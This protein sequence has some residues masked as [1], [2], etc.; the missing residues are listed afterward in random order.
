MPDIIP[1]NK[2]HNSWLFVMV[3]LACFVISVGVRYQQ[4]EIW[5]ATPANYFVGER[6]MM[7]TLD[8]PYWLR[9]AREYNE[10]VYGIDILRNY[11]GQVEYY[12]AI[13]TEFADPAFTNSTQV[14]PKLEYEGI[15][16]LSFLIS[17][18]TT[19]FDNNYY[20]TGTLIIPVLAS[21]FILPLGVYFFLIGIPAVGLI[22]GLIGTFA[23]GYYMRS[24]IGRID[25]DMLN[26][27]FPIFASLLILMSSTAKTERAIVFY[28]ASAGLSFY[29]FQWWYGRA[30]FA[31]VYFA[32]LVFCLFTRQVR[33]RIIMFS[34][35]LFI[36]FTY[37]ETFMNGTN[38]VKGFVQT[39]FVIEETATNSVIE[40]GINPAI[41][42]NVMNTI[43]EADHVPIEVVMRR[44]L[45]NSM[46]GWVG[47]IAFFGLAVL[48]W[49]ELLPLLPMLALGMLSFQSSNRFIMYLAPFIGMGLGWLLQ[50]GIETMFL[51]IAKY[52]DHKILKGKEKSIKVKRERQ[53][54]LWVSFKSLVTG[55]DL[56]SNS[57]ETDK[58]AKEES[59]NVK[60]S[61][62]KDLD[63]DWFRWARQGVLYLGIATFFWVISPQ[64]AI[65]FVPGPSIHPRLYA[66]FL[67][68]KKRVPENSAL[69]TWWDYGYAITDA[70]SLATFH[71]GG[72]QNGPKTYF[73][74]R[75][76]TS[77]NPM[78]FYKI[79]QYLSTEGGS[80]INRNNT[81]PDELLRAIRNPSQTPRNPIY[82]F[83]TADMTGK[84]G[85]ISR[86]GSWD[87]VN[88]GSQ[89][90]G[91]RNLTC[92]KVTNVE[93]NCRGAKI[94]LKD[95]KINNQIPLRRLVFIRDG[96]VFREQKFGR[97]EGYTIQL[98]VAGRQ[99][100]EVQLIDEVVFRSNYNQMF[101]LG[102]Y[103]KD[104]FEET[105]NAFPYSRL[106][107]VKF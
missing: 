30:G 48:R 32:V 68:V 42:P 17:C 64:T 41:F 74:A 54:S 107:G 29:L 66:T 27:F 67:E 56:E 4:F 97:T 96:Q 81:S 44:V 85:A 6:P 5:K 15:P 58:K 36:L 19:F 33:L 1:P 61:L 69:L 35:F 71:D 53:D 23:G 98:L 39:Y 9:L 72:S 40:T 88:G 80:G 89:P 65:S 93:I 13:P 103:R 59:K 28:S 84:Y 79:I 49:R 25:T 37:P 70:T 2:K 102:R 22:G 76:L 105:Y 104:L 83:F 46:F 11:P 8:A 31:L 91:Y 52:F 50:L 78:D 86:I 3:L 94:D 101:L 51:F 55:E 12:R 75:G 62:W 60:V 34:A 38:T 16:L 10:G 47:F 77:P 90:R 82:L 26:L 21:L 57:K 45:Y 24:S 14:T 87:I 18:L 7:T 106:F 63:I 20:L 43:S 92:N 95:G 100:V 99:I 73:I